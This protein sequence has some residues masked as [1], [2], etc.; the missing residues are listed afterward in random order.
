M[1]WLNR[2]FNFYLDASIHVALAVISLVLITNLY[3]NII[4]GQHLIL[5]V[6]FGTIPSYN[7]IKYGVEAK[8]Y[9]LVKNSYH[10]QIQIFSFI[11]LTLAGYHFFFL[12]YAV[13]FICFVLA[14]LVGLYALPVSSKHKN[15]RNSGILK[16]LLVA[17]VWTGTTVVI[18]VISS[19]ISFS[20]DIGLLILQQFIL[21]LILLIPFE[22][23]DLEYD[24]LNLKTIPQR[25]GVSQTKN[26][27]LFLS[28]IFYLITFLKDD[29]SRL[30]IIGKTI[31]FLI[32][33]I[34]LLMTRRNQSK[35]FAS[36][37][38]E[39]IPICWLGILIVLENYL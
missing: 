23:R 35:Y 29:L 21:I 16:V 9:I 22:I 6:F 19:T 25:I 24:E 11:F 32:L 26:L 12:S 13:W 20:W 30:E 1:G 38:V 15:L 2:I 18:P 8:K 34:M 4:P 33:I 37:F 31:L 5:F 10:R 39:S 28:L 27:G 3:L 7:F 36:F 17:L 14:L